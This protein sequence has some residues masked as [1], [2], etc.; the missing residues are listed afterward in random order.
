MGNKMIMKMWIHYRLPVELSIMKIRNLEALQSF[1]YLLVWV[2][3]GGVEIIMNSVVKKIEKDDLLIINPLDSYHFIGD[4]KNTLAIIDLGNKTPVSTVDNIILASDCGRDKQIRIVLAKILNTACQ[5]KPNWKVLLESFIPSLW[6][7]LL[8]GFIVH[9][10]DEIPSQ[11][12]EERINQV[13]Q[14][15]LHNYEQ[16]ITLDNVAELVYLSSAYLSRLFKQCCGISFYSYLTRV[17]LNR[18]VELLLNTDDSINHIAHKCGFPSDKSFRMAFIAAHN[19]TPGEFRDKSVKKEK[20]LG[21]IPKE[22]GNEFDQE[23]ILKYIDMEKNDTVHPYQV[24]SVL[25]VNT[26]EEGKPIRHTWRRLMGFG[27]AYELLYKNTQKQVMDFSKWGHFEYI[28]LTGIFHEDI[29]IYREDEQ[30]ITCSFNNLDDIIDFITSI[31]LKPFINFSYMPKTLASSD[32]TLERNKHKH[33]TSPPSDI[34]KWRMLI[35]AAIMHMIDRYGIDEVKTWYFETWAS[36]EM[37]IFWNGTMDEYHELY[38]STYQSIRKYLP[39]AKIGG[40]GFIN[41]NIMNNNILENFIEFCIKNEV[42]PDFLSFHLYPVYFSENEEL[43]YKTLQVFNQEYSRNF[44]QYETL[45]KSFENRVSL[46]PDNYMEKN[47]KDISGRVKEILPDTEFFITEWNS[48]AAPFAEWRDTCL[49]ASYIAK[50]IVELFDKVSGL[51]YWFFSDLY[52]SYYSRANLFHGGR[53]VVCV[54]GLKKASFHV[55]ALLAGMGDKMICRGNGYLVTKNMKGD[56][57]ILL[58]NYIHVT[59]ENLRLLRVKL[60]LK[61]LSESSYRVHNKILNHKHGSAYDL[62]LELGSPGNIKNEEL[63]YL[64]KKAVPL[65]TMKIYKVDSVLQLEVLMEPQEVR[66]LEIRKI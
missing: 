55:F 29:L 48:S 53:G 27:F 20:Q 31:G 57:Q 21:E 22:S 5:R 58:Y 41:T 32:S 43:G 66:F 51:N 11:S 16:T 54:N 61:G 24:N 52:E 4:E 38:L 33:Y 64:E 12:G 46:P 36:P 25:T 37:K 14:Y 8:N 3:D 6:Y 56:F 65:E 15:I 13:K 42:I 60:E 26:T 1:N 49:Q 2:I 34:G 35:E 19:Q 7:E 18:A 10:A 30:G 44:S 9:G 62:W 17:R 59:E 50:T 63:Q 39:D 45:Q 23:I 28:M 47:L 40:A